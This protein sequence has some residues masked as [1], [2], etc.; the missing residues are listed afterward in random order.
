LVEAEKT[1]A[2]NIAKRG[3]L[4]RRRVSAALRQQAHFW[5]AAIHKNAKLQHWRGVWSIFAPESAPM[6]EFGFSINHHCSPNEAQRKPE[7]RP[8]IMCPRMRCSSI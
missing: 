5:A 3:N 2:A 4:I 8:Q 1:E 7:L 6:L